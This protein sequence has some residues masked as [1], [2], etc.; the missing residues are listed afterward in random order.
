MRDEVDPAAG[1]EAGAP[2]AGRDA[3]DWARDPAAQRLC[4]AWRR[5]GWRA[6]RLDPL[7]L[8][9]PEAPPALDLPGPEPL[10]AA[11]RAIYG[12][13]LGW[14][15]G[16]VQDP[17]RF[18]WLA[19]EAEIA[20]P[21]SDADRA[22]A[23]ALIASAELLE[24]DVKRRLPT[25]KTFGMSGAEGF[26]LLMDEAI[27]ASGARRVVAGG[28]HRGRITQMALVLGKPLTR[29]AAELR[30]APDLPASLGAASD[31]PY[32]LGFDGVRE[33][34]VEVWTAPHPSHLS[35]VGPVALGR[36][37][38]E[39]AGRDPAVL[40]MVL[41]TDAAL[42][43]QGVNM[44]M[45]QLARLPGYSVGGTLHLL[46]DNQVGFTT[47]GPEARSARTAADVAKITETPILHVNG[48]DPDA[49][50]LAARAAARWRARWG[51]DILVRLIAYR[52]RGH[53]EMDEARFTQ[54]RMYAAIDAL[55]PLSER[56]AAAAGLPAPD[57]SALRAELDAA[58]AAP[59]ATPNAPE[60]P[61][62][63]AGAE[64][65]MLA[66]HDTGVALDELQRLAR[67]LA[68]PP[69]GMTLHPKIQQFLTRRRKMARGEAPVDWAFAEA[70]AF[71]SLLAEGR[72]LRFSGQ[73]A[74]R[75]AF[76][77]RHLR[78]HDQQT[79]EVHHSLAQFGEAEVF[80]S[81]LIENAALGF[82]YGYA[83][84]APGLDVWEAQFGDFLNVF[85][86]MFD[87]YLTGGEDRWLL[88]SRLTMLLP[89]GWDGGGPD[90]ST[91]H[92]ERVLARCA[93]ANLIAAN[94]STPAQYF[95]L[96]RR[97]MALPSPKP[98]AVF[99][100]KLLLRLAACTSAPE[101]F[102]PG[103][104][105][106]PVLAEDVSGA[107][108]ILLCSGKVYWLLAKARADRGLEGRVALVR[109]EQLHPFPA[110]ALAAALA[111]APGELVFVQEEPE[112]L[113]PFP[114]LDRRIERALG[115]PAR[116][117]SRPEAASPAVG[118]HAW[119]D[120]EEKTLIDAALDLE[121][122]A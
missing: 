62:L 32:H 69:A 77:Q 23:L 10:R 95:H 94:P 45:L 88:T 2:A 116:L 87:Q 115:R 100:P 54:P 53:N 41:H 46:L 22:R 47:D 89:H 117:V 21:P 118:W 24:G 106:A 119:H 61:G 75:G 73:D 56:F 112:N 85:Q 28:M 9:A 120:A 29:V 19:A 104:G 90:H 97:Q 98:L 37:R 36:A 102:A 20:E 91:G 40:P 60:A 114:W 80:N 65:P 68:Q 64:A 11:L 86:P 111:G 57:L 25:T 113:G 52:R 121:A 83:T 48:D 43:G 49:I 109:L 16:H 30:G 92:V 78:L 15:I 34:G 81:P 96:L 35:I 33:D 84:A 4:E 8:A 6:A 1:R 14:E 71:A 101:E 13:G 59:P 18:D 103:T 72:P 39:G 70:L 27:R 3:D 74:V 82:E 76:A 110:E 63:A 44:E 66:H 38:A 17:A 5:H 55:P 122:S 67:A 107:Q 99:T 7:G 51:E 50:L 79:G 26:A 58:F 108:R 12:G 42:A 31:V 105:F 93:K